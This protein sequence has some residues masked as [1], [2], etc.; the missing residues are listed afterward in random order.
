MTPEEGMIC[1]LRRTKLNN[2]SAF[3]FSLAKINVL[4]H[5]KNRLQKQIRKIRFCAVV[6]VSLAKL[7]KLSLRV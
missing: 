5:V 3:Q 1:L 4:R 6:V 2:M 7:V